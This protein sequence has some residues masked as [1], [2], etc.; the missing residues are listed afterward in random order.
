MF[1]KLFKLNRRRNSGNEEF[2]LSEVL[3]NSQ[4]II[5]MS[6][7]HESISLMRE[8][9]LNLGLHSSASFTK[10]RL[11][12]REGTEEIVVAE[13]PSIIEGKML[14]KSTKRLL[15]D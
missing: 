5:Y 10:I 9:K 6:E 11:S 1:I 12:S 15:R 7:D 8:G 14:T 3:V 2:Y 4:Q 13:S